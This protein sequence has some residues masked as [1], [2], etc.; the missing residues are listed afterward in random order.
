MTVSPIDSLLLAAGRSLV[1]PVVVVGT[2]AAINSACNRAHRPTRAPA[3]EL[4]RRIALT[5]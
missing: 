2:S 1:R 3:C 5:H 4:D